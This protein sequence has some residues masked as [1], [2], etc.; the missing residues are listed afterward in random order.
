METDGRLNRYLLGDCTE[1]EKIEIERRYFADESSFEELLARE[2]ELTY[3]YLS[4]ELARAD[5]EKF[6]RRFVRT[7]AGPERLAFAR[8]LL[9]RLPQSRRPPQLHRWLGVAAAILLAAVPAWLVVETRRLDRELRR[10]EVERS[11]ISPAPPPQGVVAAFILSPGLA[12]SDAE[13]KRLTLPAGVTTIELRFELRRGAGY[14]SYRAV[15]RTAAGSEL[16]NEQA[17]SPLLRVPAALLA[18]GDYQVLLYGLAAGGQP[19]EA[20]DY[21]FSVLP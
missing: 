7:Q 6:E 1:L 10:L 17:G 16:F 21:Y 4:G 20:G 5:R 9:A 13:P 11:G 12:R 18:P 8:A 14:A 15:L 3:E 2:D 19:E